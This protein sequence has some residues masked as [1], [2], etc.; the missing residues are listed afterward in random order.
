MISVEYVLF[1]LC[2][3]A[4]WSLLYRENLAYR[5]AE[6]FYVG[7]TAANLLV[8]AWESALKIAWTPVT[9]GNHLWILPLILSIPFVLF[10]HR[11]TRSLY[12]IPIA[13]VVSVGT[14]LAMRGAIH[15]DIVGQVGASMKSLIQPGPWDNSFNTAVLTIGSFATL[16]YFLFTKE[17]KGALSKVPRVGR[18]FIMAVVGAAYAN[19][20]TG[21][22]ANYSGILLNLLKTDAVYIAAGALVVIA[23]D[24][25][26]R[27]AKKKP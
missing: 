5:I 2:A 1:G 19:T 25:L 20:G 3:V 22:L 17:V 12:M 15:A 18:L 9:K 21:R 7:F 10:F 24:I 26:R 16:S 4:I 11:K 27:R 8:Q 23:V 6:Y 13:V 14:G